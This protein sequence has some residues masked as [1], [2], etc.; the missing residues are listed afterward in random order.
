MQCGRMSA[1]GEFTDLRAAAQTRLG[2]IH[3]ARERALPR[4][5]AAIRLCATAIRA[6]HRGEQPRAAELI[7][8][9]Q[10]LLG[11]VASDL[12]AFPAIAAAGFL[13]DAQKE[14]AEA[15]TVAAIVRG[16]APPGPAEL[17]MDWAPYLNGLGEA[18]GELRRRV[19]DD[20][21]RGEYAAGEGWL[22]A[23]DDILAL[24]AALDFPDAITNNLRRT[25]DAARGISER[26]RGDLTMA[27]VQGR[28]AAQMERLAAQFARR[29]A[30][31]E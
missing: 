1:V 4:T 20:L 18:V 17:G 28:A 14:L 19:L 23:M 24:L 30:N 7:A 12:R 22:A 11:A 2:A 3:E 26:T 27:M 10:D 31:G 29:A 15:A 8:E 16:A 6:V 25:T 13:E 9:A 5:R 21:R